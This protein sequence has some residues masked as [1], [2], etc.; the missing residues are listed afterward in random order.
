MQALLGT[1]ER[2]DVWGLLEALA[3]GDGKALLE[4]LEALAETALDFDA[5]LAELLE[6][7]QM[8]A[9]LQ[10]VPNSMATDSGDG[11]I[12][13]AL[14]SALTPEDVQ[15][16]Y[17]IGIQGRRDLPFAPTLKS[18]FEMI[19]LRML[20]FKPLLPEPLL[21]ESSTPA[22]SVPP[23]GAPPRPNTG[24]HLASNDLAGNGAGSN[25]ASGSHALEAH[26]PLDTGL[27]GHGVLATRQLRDEVPVYEVVPHQGEQ[28]SGDTATD[29][30][31][32]ERWAGLIA[33]LGLTGLTGELAANCEWVSEQSGVVHLRIAPSYAQ[34]NS[35]RARLGLQD[36]LT[37]RLGR[38]TKIS[39]TVGERDSETPAQRATRLADERLAEATASLREDP[40]V[41]EICDMFGA[42]VDPQAVRLASRRVAR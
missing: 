7:L 18:G 16:F 27:S 42:V 19:M 11:Q 24:G 25:G 4:A 35:E 26:N 20:A 33:R 38:Q 22:A 28:L 41:A 5:L 34:L 6:A 10:A 31:T 12:A 15:L 1:P 39:V 3:C 14:S 29:P 32:C 2:A 30:M 36:A 9:V 40:K 37:A 23:S 21:P 13:A 17:Q 8:L